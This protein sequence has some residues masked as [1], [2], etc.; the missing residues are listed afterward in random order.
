VIN[1]HTLDY[2]EKYWIFVAKIY[3]IKNTTA[4]AV[5]R[6]PTTTITTTGFFYFYLTGLI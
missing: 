2:L 4:A 1:K 6:P 5:L 3:M